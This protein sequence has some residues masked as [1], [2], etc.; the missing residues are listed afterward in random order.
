MNWIKKNPETIAAIVFIGTIVSLF[1]FFAVIPAI[2]STRINSERL[3]FC[4]ANGFVGYDTIGFEPVCYGYVE[5]N[6]LVV[7]QIESLR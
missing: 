3:Q 4:K 5:K 7:V 1:V 6:Q 2:K